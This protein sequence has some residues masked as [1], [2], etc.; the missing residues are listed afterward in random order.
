M[1]NPLIVERTYDAP[2]HLVWK[3]LTDADQMKQW[4]FDIPGFKP[5]LGFEFSFTGENEGKIFIHH[6]KILEVIP[7]KKLKHSWSYEGYEGVSYVT[8]EIFP[9]GRKTRVRLTHEGL[10]S[11]P[12]IPDFAAEN[13]KE[14]WTMILGTLLTEF[15]EKEVE[16]ED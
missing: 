2:A 4:Y 9:E 11:F 14:G 7:E 6:C 3:A 1:N 16:Q 10:D 12:S 8:F 15:L 13:F 5:E